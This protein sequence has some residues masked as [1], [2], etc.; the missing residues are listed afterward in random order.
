M[1]FNLC[2]ASIRCCLIPLK[3]VGELAK[4]L[5]DSKVTLGLLMTDDKLYHEARDTVPQLK[6]AVEDF[7]Q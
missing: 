2:V 7:S 6:E 4:L 5:K 1:K 3:M